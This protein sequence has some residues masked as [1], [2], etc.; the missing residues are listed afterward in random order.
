[1]ER[2][3][4]IAL[5]EQAYRIL[6]KY[7]TTQALLMSLQ[8]IRFMPKH[9]APQCRTNSACQLLLYYGKYGKFGF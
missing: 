6:N 5:A 1:M 4:I 7:Q 2:K 9:Q 8:K 3:N